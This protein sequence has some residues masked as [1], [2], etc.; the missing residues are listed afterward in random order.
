M[1]ALAASPDEGRALRQ[2]MAEIVFR[3]PP[4]F[5]YTFR[6]DLYNQEGVAAVFGRHAGNVK[7]APYRLQGGPDGLAEIDYPV[8]AVMIKS[9]WIS[10]ARAKDLGLVENPERP[11]V[12]MTMISPV[13]DNNAP[14]FQKGDYWLVALHVSS[15]DVPNWVWAS[16]EHV[17]NPGRCDYTGCNDSWGYATPDAVGPGQARN[18]TAPLVRCDRLPLAGWVFDTGKPYPGGSLAPALRAVLDDLGIGSSPAAAASGGRFVPSRRDRAWRSYRLK[19]AQTEF[20]DSTGR[21][22]ILGNSVTEGGFVSTSSCI[23]CHARAASGPK[24]PIPPPLGVFVNELGETGY[25]QSHRGIPLADWYHRSGQPPALQA[26][27]TDF[28]WGFLGANCV[29]P[30]CGCNNE[31]DS[32]RTR[33]H[34]PLRGSVRDA[35]RGRP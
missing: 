15:K 10:A 8:Q 27:Q 24:G 2:S 16:F 20:V 31:P 23:S 1:A 13:T 26:L 5:D 12:K 19:G 3:N 30:V 9:N 33:E 22:T 21:T 6:N 28:V 32:C 11:Y 14:I 25:G 7:D 34:V 18:Y 17:D 29:T 4:M 35:A